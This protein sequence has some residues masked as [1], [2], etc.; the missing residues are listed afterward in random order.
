MG[1]LLRNIADMRERGELCDVIVMVEKEQFQ[2]HRLVLAAGS[3][4]FHAMFTSGFQEK[5]KNEIKLIG[6]TAANFRSFLCFVYSGGVQ[7]TDENIE[8]LY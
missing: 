3:D 5:D 2:L 8:E 7:L 4:F 1:I 6:Q